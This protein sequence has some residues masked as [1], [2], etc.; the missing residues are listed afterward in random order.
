MTSGGSTINNSKWAN[1]LNPVALNKGFE[2]PVK[3]NGY[4]DFSN[5]L[6]TGGVFEVG[7]VTP[8]NTVRINLTGSYTADFAAANRAAGFTT[9]PDNFT[10][11]HSEVLGELQLIST[12]AHNAARHSGGVQLYREQHGG[13]GY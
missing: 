8:M 6:Y 13:Q 5:Y 7:V 1:Q 2:V 11:H 12:D 10:W 3:A 4:P 9:T